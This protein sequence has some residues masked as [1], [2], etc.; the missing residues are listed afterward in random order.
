MR[1]RAAFV[2]R[3]AGV[4]GA[5]TLGMTHHGKCGHHA[6]V[7]LHGGCVQR[8]GNARQTTCAWRLVMQA[9]L[10]LTTGISAS[11]WG[12]STYNL[13][14]NQILQLGTAAQRSKTA[15]HCT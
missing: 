9:V 7:H 14:F 11:R 4:D 5:F 10:V 12:Y 15:P 6:V 13:A 3:E 2:G 8:P 1:C